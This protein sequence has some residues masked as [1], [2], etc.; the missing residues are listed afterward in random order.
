MTLVMYHAEY[1]V[2]KL[3]TWAGLN[4][5]LKYGWEVIGEL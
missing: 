5:A 2:I 3:F 4:D 1:D